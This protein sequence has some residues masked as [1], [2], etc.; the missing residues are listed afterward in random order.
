MTKL[1]LQTNEKWSDEI[2]N[3]PFLCELNE[4]INNLGLLDLNG[5]HYC[6]CRLNYKENTGLVELIT[7]KEE[8][9]DMLY[10]DEITC[11]YCGDEHSD[12][13]EMADDDSH[14]ECGTC[15]GIFSYQRDVEVT[16]NSS[17]VSPPEALAVS[18]KE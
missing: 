13:W 6:V 17:P 2:T 8:P 15:G 11:P 9:E 3:Y 18:A 7:L 16:Y 14:Y 1:Y 10:E 12:S 5:K 4:D